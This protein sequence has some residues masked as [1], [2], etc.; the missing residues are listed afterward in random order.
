VQG[1]GTYCAGLWYLLC[2]AGALGLACMHISYMCPYQLH[3]SKQAN[4]FDAHTHMHA[5]WLHAWGWGAQDSKGA[6][7]A[8]HAPPPSECASTHAH[9]HTHTHTRTRFCTNDMHQVHMPTC[10]RTCT[11]APIH[12]CTSCPRTEAC[13]SARTCCRSSASI[14]SLAWRADTSSRPSAS[15]CTRTQE[16]PLA[17]IGQ[18]RINA[19]ARQS[20]HPSALARWKARP[21]QHAQ[22]CTRRALTPVDT[23]IDPHPCDQQHPHRPTPM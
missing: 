10:T 19:H 6:L 11:H 22:A 16:H 15:H 8:W 21:H 17:R 23:R 4:K 1:C 13:A 9:T 7:H 14:L 18:A 12:A 20:R 5:R 3:E 2:R